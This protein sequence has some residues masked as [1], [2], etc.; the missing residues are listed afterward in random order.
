MANIKKHDYESLLDLHNIKVLEEFVK[1]FIVEDKFGFK[2][3]LYKNSMVKNVSLTVR[4]L[5]DKT[6]ISNYYLELIKERHTN[7]SNLSNFEKFNYETALSYTTATCLKHGDYRTKPNWLLTRGHHCSKCN[8]EARS[9]RAKIDTEEYIRR[10]KVIHGDRFDYSKTTYKGARELVTITCREHGDFEIVAYYHSSDTCGCQVCGVEKSAIGKER[11][12]KARNA[13]A[14]VYVASMFSETE[15]FIK[16]GLSKEPKKRCRKLQAK[17][18]Y[19]VKLLYS[20]LFSDS[21]VAW[22]VEQLL[23]K[24]FKDDS[25]RPKRKFGGSTECFNLSV[26]SEVIKLLQCM[27]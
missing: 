16:V 25:Y 15:S 13:S 20:N 12:G 5:F 2:H 7:I 4:S 21:E 6:Q 27:A 19:K 14:E 22:D 3:K 11:Y 10:A 26:E 1:F 8:D 23:H 9:D 17:C 18:G 24:E